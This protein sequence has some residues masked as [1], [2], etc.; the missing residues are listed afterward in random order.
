MEFMLLLWDELDDVAAACRHITLSAMDEVT[1]I[2]GAVG[3]AVVAF[4]V[5]LLRLP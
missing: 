5:S 3:A 4:A 1:E 2:S